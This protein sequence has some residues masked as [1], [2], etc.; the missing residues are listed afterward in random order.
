MLPLYH[1]EEQ[2]VIQQLSDDIELLWRDSMA[3]HWEVETFGLL[4]QTL[5]NWMEWLKPYSLVTLETSAVEKSA[6]E[7]IET[8][9]KVDRGP[10]TEATFKHE[11]PERIPYSMDAS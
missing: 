8:Y 5:R 6:R 1:E 7:F 10:L 3:D 4:R 11:T 9:D 2:E